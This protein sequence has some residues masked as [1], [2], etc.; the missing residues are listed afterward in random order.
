VFVGLR[1]LADEGEDPLIGLVVR[2]EGNPVQ[3]TVVL[4]ILENKNNVRSF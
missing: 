4:H 2:T 1:V 3:L